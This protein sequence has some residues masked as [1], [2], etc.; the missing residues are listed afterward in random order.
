[1]VRLFTADIQ[2]VITVTWVDEGIHL[3]VH[4]ALLVAGRRQV[5]LVDCVSFELMRRLDVDRAFCF[6]PHFTEQGFT[7]S[8]AA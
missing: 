4:H 7:V 5:S 1:M 3:S 2:P 6:D 8:P